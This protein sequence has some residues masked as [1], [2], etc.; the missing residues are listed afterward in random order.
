MSNLTFLTYQNALLLYPKLDHE[1]FTKINIYYDL[2][3]KWQKTIP[4]VGGKENILLH[5][6][7]SLEFC[8]L[9]HNLLS[10]QNAP[11]SIVDLGTGNGF[12]AIIISIILGCDIICTEKNFKKCC[13][14][15]EVIRILN[16]KNIT[17]HSGLIEKL[18]LKN[19]TSYFISRALAD[20]STIFNY[21][22][23]V[24]RETRVK[25][26]LF[27][28]KKIHQEIIKAKEQ[29]DFSYTLHQSIIKKEGVICEINLI[30]GRH[31][32]S[33]KPERWSGKNH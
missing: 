23:I 10:S 32:N 1:S 31:N 26:L 25:A 9:L 30:N 29:W 5:F 13:F 17:L 7:D 8:Y 28:G 12:P 20:L 19:N 18:E 27:K 24:S 6:L 3:L 21:I 4:L 15:K 16:L 2:L 11:Y 14:L 22:T 33:S